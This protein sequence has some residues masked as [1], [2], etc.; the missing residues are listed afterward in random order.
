[1]MSWKLTAFK[2]SYMPLK[3]IGLGGILVKPTPDLV[4]LQQELIDA[5]A[6]F[7][8]PAGCG[9]AAAFVTTPQDPDI[10]QATLDAVATY[11]AGQTGEHYSPHVTTGVG[12]TDYL[13]G[14][15][16]ARFPNFTFS[17]AGA[18]IY[19]F[20]NFGLAAKRLHSFE[21]TQ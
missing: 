3:E 4:R 18:S 21:L 17:P 7:M 8:A 2:Y 16:A 11:L 19:Q 1:V 15:H 9:T 10:D 5:T 6:A 13:T 20:G 14:L 12:T